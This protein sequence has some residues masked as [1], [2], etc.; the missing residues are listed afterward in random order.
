MNTIKEM[1]ELAEKLKKGFCEFQIEVFKKNIDYRTALPARINIL[2]EY[3]LENGMNPKWKVEKV[4]GLWCIKLNLHATDHDK[5][6]Y[7]DIN[8]DGI[9]AM[10][11]YGIDTTDMPEDIATELKKQAYSDFIEAVNFFQKL[12]YK[13]LDK[14]VRAADFYDEPESLKLQ[15]I[16]F[17]LKVALFYFE[18]HLKMLED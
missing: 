11:F 13:E 4:T 8:K 12:D 9:N 3:L 5:V 18:E 2:Q 1:L 14:W 15:S 10:Q 7:I 17:N 6:A 16:M